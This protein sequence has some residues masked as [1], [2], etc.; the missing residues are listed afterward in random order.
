MFTKAVGKIEGLQQ[1]FITSSLKPGDLLDFATLRVAVRE[2]FYN[3]QPVNLDAV[4]RPLMR[5]SATAERNCSRHF[6][7][8]RRWKVLSACTARGKRSMSS[9]T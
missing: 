1:F 4:D 7:M 6:S 5:H 9:S 2:L 8:P 3:R